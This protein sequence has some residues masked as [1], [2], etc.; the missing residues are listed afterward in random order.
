MRPPAEVPSGTSAG[1]RRRRPTNQQPLVESFPAGDPAATEAAS[2][3]V[4]ASRRVR[5][6]AS[7]VV[8]LAE[9]QAGLGTDKNVMGDGS[10]TVR[11]LRLDLQAPAL[12]AYAYRIPLMPQHEQQAA[13]DH[14]IAE[15]GRLGSRYGTAV[16]NGALNAAAAGIDSLKAYSRARAEE[17]VLSGGHVQT[18]AQLHGDVV[19]V[20]GLERMSIDGDGPAGKAV[21]VWQWS[22]Q[23]AAR[24]FGIVLNV[25]RLEGRCVDDGPAGKAVLA[26]GN[27]AAIAQEFDINP[28]HIRRMEMM[29][30]NGPAGEAVRAAV[31]AAFR[32][33]Q[34]VEVV[35]VEQCGN[36]GIKGEMAVGRLRV[37]AYQTSRLGANG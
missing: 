22:V 19:N 6:Q 25:S 4:D 2:R 32:A 21:V 15:A 3:E 35:V 16:L 36:F 1:I 12:A 33:G 8:R 27:V 9:F 28:T 14:L 37:I 26:G 13:V 24:K 31:R 10:E 7:K 18:I 17:A 30:A 5:D 34:D 20:H 29:S 11:S 23:T